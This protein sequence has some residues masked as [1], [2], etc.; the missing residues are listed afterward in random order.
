MNMM[1]VMAMMERTIEGWGGA[2]VRLR[3][4]RGLRMVAFN[5]VGDTVTCRGTVADVSGAPDQVTIDLWLETSSDR[6]TAAATAVVRLDGQ[7]R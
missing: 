6:R 3:G 7:T 5:R 1:F 2:R 4:L